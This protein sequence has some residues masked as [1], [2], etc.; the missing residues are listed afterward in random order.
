VPISLILALGWNTPIYLWVFDF[1]PGFGFFQAPARLLIWYTL[2]VAVLA[3]VGA[4]SFKLTPSSRRG[5]QRLLVTAGG[6]TIAGQAGSFILT[7]RSRTF[8]EATLMLGLWLIVSAS[9][10]L[11]RPR[12]RSTSS[13]ASRLALSRQ[14]IWKVAVLLF[15]AFD[16]LG[17]AFP[18]NPTLPAAI[19]RQP[20][21]SA[22]FLNAQPD[23]YRYYVAEKFDY[24][25]K[26]NRYFSFTAFGPADLAYWQGLKET[27][28]PN[29]GI[30]AGL[31]SANNYDPLT[32]GRW[33]KLIDLVENAS[34][35]Q[36]AR[37][38]ALMNVG[39]FIGDSA[40]NVGPALYTDE[41]MAIQSL[42][43]ALPRAYLASQ[44]Y[45]ARDEAEV[46]AR[47]LSPD[48]DSRLEVII[49][50]GEVAIKAKAE[51]EAE[52]KIEEKVGAVTVVE[53][54]SNQVLLR[55]EAPTA[56]FVVLTDTF[57]PGWQ[58]TV[59]GQPAQIWP[60]NL[61]FRAVA[62]EAGAH[63]IIFSYRPRSFII[64]LG[65]STVTLALLV[66]TLIFL[67]QRERKSL[68]C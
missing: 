49:M 2:A 36:Q 39:Y 50:G 53:E 6:L 20:I 17:V 51:A 68:Q 9:L 8:L 25:L 38:L 3:G 32:V 44:V 22:D 55:V 14:T 19:F 56:G 60:A 12:K 64:G 42:P 62:V 23:N 63:E 37:L 26:F 61:A 43:E 45:H 41:A 16:L 24:A 58:A 33:Q 10:L 27:L 31:A 35:T 59:D 21:A 18:L 29:L 40:Q 4:Q 5:W 34:A 1:V 46:V 48:F 57:Y 54:R 67:I 65:V 11:L 13:N 47:L 7:G 28:I 30:Y 52:A 66:I 15:V